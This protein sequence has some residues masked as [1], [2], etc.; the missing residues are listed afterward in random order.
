MLTGWGVRVSLPR[1]DGLCT[2]TLLTS[3]FGE[4]YAQAG[5]SDLSFTGENQD[6]VPGLYDFPFREYA[7]QGRWPSPDPRARCGEP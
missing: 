1:L 6:T 7:T 4:P 5:T 2:R 3:P